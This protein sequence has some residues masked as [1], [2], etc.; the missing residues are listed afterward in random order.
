MVSLA[1]F[2]HC[3]HFLT[4]SRTNFQTGFE[5]FFRRLTT[6][7]LVFFKKLGHRW[8]SIELY[9]ASSHASLVS[10]F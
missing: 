4:E 9:A 1:L 8:S 5:E 3:P 7:Y 6:Q 2:Q 10:Q